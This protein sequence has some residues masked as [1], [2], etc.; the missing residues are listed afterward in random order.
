MPSSA[1]LGSR[2][3]RSICIGRWCHG[4]SSASGSSNGFSG[5]LLPWLSQSCTSNWS[6]AAA[7]TLTIVAGLNSSRVRS[8]RLTRRGFGSSSCGSGSGK[9][10][11]S[12]TLRPKRWPIIPIAGWERSFQLPSDVRSVRSRPS[13]AAGF[14]S[15]SPVS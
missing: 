13:A 14:A 7:S 15:L 6:H 10:L 5:T 4:S 1:W 11:A 2:R 9:V 12:G 8:F 3:V